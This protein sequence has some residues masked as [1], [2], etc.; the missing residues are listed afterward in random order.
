MKKGQYY[1]GKYR[2]INKG[3]Y[4]GNYNAV[5]YRS[6]WERQVFRWCDEQ[7]DVISWSSEETII[8]YRCKTDNKIHRYFVDLKI[9]F[10]NGQTYLIEIKPKKQVEVPKIRSKKTKAY[11]TEVLTYAKNQSKW[12]AASEYCADR[13]WIFEVWTEDT[14]KALGIKLLT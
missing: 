2:V 7:P 9:R 6:L 5:S 13:G 4:D 12:S 3:K 14:I 11:I 8:H 10:K 1:S